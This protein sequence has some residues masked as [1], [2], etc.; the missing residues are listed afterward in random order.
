MTRF[1]P[2][3]GLV[4]PFQTT[5]ISPQA[6]PFTAEALDPAIIECKLGGNGGRTTSFS[7][8]GDDAFVDTSKDF[9]ESNREST[10][11]KVE[12]E[13]DPDQFVEFCRADKITLTGKKK[14]SEAPRATSFDTESG[15]DPGSKDK[16]NIEYQYPPDKSCKPANP[17]KG[18]N[19]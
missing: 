5:S 14:S 17:D 8:N 3:E 2:M 4:R 11:V 7:V 18:G 16:Q 1:V 12:N 6:L 10:L 15:T 19:C 9:K 13:E